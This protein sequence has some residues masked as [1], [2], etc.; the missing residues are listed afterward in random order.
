M[1]HGASADQAR[2]TVNTLLSGKPADA[3]D[4]KDI[5]QA[6][7]EI[8]A[9]RKLAL[10]FQGK[11]REELTAAGK[12]SNKG[13]KVKREA[14]YDKGDKVDQKTSINYVPKVIPKQPNVRELLMNTVTTSVLF[15]SYTK[16]E[17]N[18]IVD[19]RHTIHGARR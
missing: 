16:D 15:S 5:E 7:T 19:A 12:D 3:S 17:Q 13:G 2:A 10:D 4:I 9:L 11:L 1:G 18:A 8:R 14:V 6:K